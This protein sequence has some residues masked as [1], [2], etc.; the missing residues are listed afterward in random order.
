MRP[1][2]TTTVK[3]AVLIG[4]SIFLT[5]S[6]PNLLGNS[7][8]APLG[9]EGMGT[10]ILAESFGGNLSRWDAT[11]MAGMGEYYPR[12]RTTKEVV[13]S[14]THAITSDTSR[15]ALASTIPAD[16]IIRSGKARLEF[17]LT[18]K[19]LGAANFTVEIGQNAK[20]IGG[21]EKNFG[22]G[23]GRNDSLKCTY[24]DF[25]D[26]IPRRDSMMMPIAVGHW[27]KLAVE[28]DYSAKTVSYEIDDTAVRTIPARTED[29]IIDRILAFRGLDPDAPDDSPSGRKDYF[30]DDLILYQK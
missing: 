2:R 7:D 1:N 11:F 27:Y 25:T 5:C 29:L 17:Y 10:V 23:F 4:A 19:S 22:L 26:S 20:G 6:V 16:K 14:G 24:F 9:K 15:C 12:M 28:I 8:P 30:L 3:A 13:H 18:A 21:L